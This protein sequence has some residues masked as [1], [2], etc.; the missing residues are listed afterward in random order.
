MAQ[1]E[2]TNMFM[3]D[4]MGQTESEELDKCRGC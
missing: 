3:T 1:A 4:Q 2:D